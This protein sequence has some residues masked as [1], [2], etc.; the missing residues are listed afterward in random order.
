MSP[1]S[2]LAMSF[3]SLTEM[4]FDTL[5]HCLALNCHSDIVYY[6]TDR[7][8]VAGFQLFMAT[9]VYLFRMGKIKDIII[10]LNENMCFDRKT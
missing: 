4:P 3:G 7:S 1:R 5:S 10:F 8:N 6:F 9:E 2:F